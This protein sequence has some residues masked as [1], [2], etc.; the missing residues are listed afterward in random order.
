MDPTLAVK[1]VQCP[2]QLCGAAAD[3]GQREGPLGAGHRPAISNLKR[4]NSARAQRRSRLPC[5][6]TT[7]TENAGDLDKMPKSAP[8]PLQG[9]SNTLPHRPS[10]RPPPPQDF[11]QIVCGGTALFTKKVYCITYTFVQ[12]FSR[13]GGKQTLTFWAVPDNS[14]VVPDPLDRWG[15]VRRSRGEGIPHQTPSPHRPWGGT[16]KN[17]NP[18]YFCIYAV[19]YWDVTGSFPQIRQTDY[20]NA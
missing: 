13:S 16:E 10:Y 3:G 4:G 11:H 20:A 19:C 17:A 5:W 1:A 8:T 12:K 6:K 18:T 14:Q 9:G 7:G 2:Q 15:G